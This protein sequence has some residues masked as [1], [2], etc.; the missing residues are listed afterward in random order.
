MLDVGAVCL[1]EAAAAV[2][3]L[4]VEFDVVLLAAGNAAAVGA[5]VI[6]KFPEG[7]VK[8]TEELKVVLFLGVLSPTLDELNEDIL[9]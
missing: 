7:D 2:T 8:V 5:V 3:V 4:D 9:C 6:L 1:L